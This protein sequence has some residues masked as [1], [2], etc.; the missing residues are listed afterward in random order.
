MLPKSI[1]KKSTNQSTNNSSPSNNTNTP[2]EWLMEI[3][4]TDPE[5]EY[6]DLENAYDEEGFK[7][8][9]KIIKNLCDEFLI[10]STSDREKKNENENENEK[11]YHFKGESELKLNLEEHLINNIEL[12]NLSPTIYIYAYTVNTFGKYPFLQ[13]FFHT[14]KESETKTPQQYNLCIP[15]FKYLNSL[16]VLS[17]SMLVLSTICS[18]YNKDDSCYKFKG[19]LTD[20]DD[21]SLML[22]F[23]CSEL[24]IDKININRSTDLMLV[25][26]DE[27]IN[28]RKM[29][30]YIIDDHAYNFFINHIDVLQ[31]LDNNNDHYEVPTVAYTSCLTKHADF[32]LTFGVS[33]LEESVDALLGNYFYFT[34]YDS[35]S[36]SVIGKE[37]QSQYVHIRFAI[38]LDNLLIKLNNV[39]DRID[40]SEITKHFL[41]T[42]DKKS[43]EYRTVK[44][45]MRLSDRDGVWAI[46]YDSVYIGQVELDNGTYFEKYPLWVLKNYEQQVPLSTGN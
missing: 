9:N 18:T 26:V 31:L 27:I 42:L 38:F 28:H 12:N 32:V 2:N 8:Y 23:D 46:N 1:N 30:K 19:Y 35:V 21:N 11:Y 5:S 17:T 41:S 15:K 24:N 14:D 40:E 45:Q 29:G 7:D 39:Q 34:D 6:D 33:P 4:D 22:F 13:Y 37:N 20:N 3:S 25:L 16:D 36:V 10:Q 44:Y 43:K